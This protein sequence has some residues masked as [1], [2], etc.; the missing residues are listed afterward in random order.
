MVEAKPGA[1][2]PAPGPAKSPDPKPESKADPGPDSFDAAKAKAPSLTREFCEKFG[3]DEA[4]LANIAA[5]LTPP[6]PFI[7]EN[8]VTELHHDNGVWFVTAKG[9]S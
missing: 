1:G 5:G 2:R 3:L 9:K 7:P 6:P 4:Y 8:D